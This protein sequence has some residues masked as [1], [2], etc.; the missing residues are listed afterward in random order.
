MTTEPM[1][2]VKLF[3]LQ[4][5]LLILVGI[6]AAWIMVALH[7]LEFVENIDRYVTDKLMLYAALQ[8]STDAQ[9]RFLFI[10]IGETSCRTWAE[11]YGSSCTLGVVTSRRHLRNIFEKIKES[12]DDKTSKPRLVVID[13]E[14][15]PLL[16]HQDE[17]PCNKG[18]DKHEL[19]CDDLLLR[20]TILGLAADDVPVIALRPMVIDPA[21]EPAISGFP[22][23]LDRDVPEGSG[24]VGNT[25]RN[26]WFASP[27]IQADSDGVVRSIHACDKMWNRPTN[28]FEPVAAIGLLGAILLDPVVSINPDHDPQVLLA[29]DNAKEKLSEVFPGSRPD[30]IGLR[31]PRNENC[32]DLPIKVGKQSFGYATRKTK[33]GWLVNRIIFS[34]PFERPDR[35]ETPD[36]PMIRRVQAMN[37]EKGPNDGKQLANTVVMIGGSY[38]S[39]GDLRATPLG[40]EM[41]GAMVHANAI[42]AY[43]YGNLIHEKNFLNGLF[44]K[45]KFIL[46]GVAA[47]I[48]SFFY[49]LSLQRTA[50]VFI[51]VLTLLTAVAVAIFRAWQQ[52]A[53]FDLYVGTAIGLELGVCIGIV[54]PRILV[55]FSRIL[56]L[57]IGSAVA[58]VA[59]LW[60]GAGLTYEMLTAGKVI[61][62]LTPA[63][64]VAF[65]GLCVV[66]HEIREL[67]SEV[68]DP[69]PKEMI[70]GHSR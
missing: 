26:L 53:W 70:S 33:A 55:S 58:T 50:R 64:A 34:L 36:P 25:S 54:F 28:Q 27:I 68:L 30:L 1:R 63:L 43:Y 65:E 8:Q 20:N 5:F 46:I 9:L 67:A 35:A 16:R 10:D 31:P 21:G 66:L 4:L 57:L 45:V 52:Q 18:P 51:C 15:A 56:V 32:P 22:S 6:V 38:L 29:Q 7:Q 3:F 24:S 44:W 13:V 49:V 62:T 42:R 39:S 60:V 12:I 17:K 69:S 11:E 23:I 14:L 19:V 48:G 37:F 61:G 2:A 47:L 41:P 40:P 59:V